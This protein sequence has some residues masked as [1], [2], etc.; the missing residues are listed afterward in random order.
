MTGR[1]HIAV[2]VASALALNSL[3]GASS[4]CIPAIIG[5][6]LGGMFCDSDIATSEASRE[7]RFAWA[8]LAVV[9]LTS[10]VGAQL[11]GTDV[12]K[13]LAF[14]IQTATHA[15]IESLS[16][17]ASVGSTSYATSLDALFFA[18]GEHMAIGVLLLVAI[19]ACGRASGHRGFSHT[20]V[21]LV[22]SSYG[23]FLLYAPLTPYFALGYTTHLLLDVL[24]KKNIP[25][26]WPLKF[27]VSLGVARSGGI[28][29]TLLC[30]IASALT[31]VL[32][33]QQWFGPFLL[34]PEWL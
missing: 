24:T 12:I 27:G 33:L 14:A 9:I 8:A 28:L 29:D 13:Q 2:G 4:L 19:C 5:G 11:L 7:L 16:G 25:L 21:A 22:L 15:L 30:G 18:Y 20:L 10:L 32:L 34:L 3:V 23:I 1:T 31:L 26:F 6:A 17:A